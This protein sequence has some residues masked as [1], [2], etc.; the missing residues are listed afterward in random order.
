MTRLVLV[1]AA[2][3]FDAEDR[4]LLAKRPKGKAMAGLWEFPGGK[5]ESTE[6]PEDALIREL[7]EELGLSVDAVDLQAMQFVSFGYTNFHL[8]MPVFICRKWSGLPTP[9]EGQE[10]AWVKKEDLHRFDA[11]EADQPLFEYLTSGRYQEPI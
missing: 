7:Q 3:L 6:T 9:K 11:P 2:A 5:V 8:L 10:L 4:V 1:V